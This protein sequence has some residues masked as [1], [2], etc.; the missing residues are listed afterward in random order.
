MVEYY[1]QRNSFLDLNSLYTNKNGILAGLKIFEE[2]VAGKLGNIFTI[3]NY[4]SKYLQ[5]K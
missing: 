5:E 1:L 3:L 2:T 4:K